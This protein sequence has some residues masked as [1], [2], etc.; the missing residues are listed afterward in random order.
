MPDRPKSIQP[1]EPPS[2]APAPPEP[3]LPLGKNTNPPPDWEYDR[4]VRFTWLRP[5][6]DEGRAAALEAV[7]AFL[8]DIAREAGMWGTGDHRD[9]LSAVA[10]DLNSLTVYL[11]STAEDLGDHSRDEEEKGLGKCAEAWAVRLAGMVRD[12]RRTID[13]EE[14]VLEGQVYSRVLALAT[15]TLDDLT[16]VQDTL[17]TSFGTGASPQS[18]SPELRSVLGAVLAWVSQSCSVLR[19]AVL[20]ELEGGKAG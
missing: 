4:A 3:D 9:D 16:R 12:I 1:P 19:P 2:P 13:E 6:D 17:M 18:A 8:L 10:D 11:L 7:A 14:S 15:V 5:F 20:A